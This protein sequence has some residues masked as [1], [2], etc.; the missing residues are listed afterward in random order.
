VLSIATR[1][2]ELDRRLIQALQRDGRTSYAA[3]AGELGTTEKVVRTRVRSLLSSGVIDITTVSNPLALGYRYVAMVGVKTSGAA[4][5]AVAQ[6]LTEIEG[7]DYVVT[8]MGRYDIFVEVF[9]R[10]LDHLQDLIENKIKSIA[11]VVDVEASLY[12]SLV[13]QEGAFELARAKEVTNPIVGGPSI[14]LDDVDI[15]IV[16]ILNQ[17]GRTPYR[18]IAERLSI[19]ESQVRRRVA[20]MQD[21]NVMKIMAITNPMSLGFETVALVGAIVVPPVGVQEAARTIAKIRSVTYV[22][23]AAGRFDLWLELVCSDPGDLLRLIDEELR[24]IPGITRLE[25]FVYLDLRYRHVRTA[26]ADS[27]PA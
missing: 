22:A 15:S 9:C 11:G 1:L 24:Q 2:S 26:G 13:Y 6:Q 10:T 23:I 21:A 14:D 12:L 5:S 19:S 8:T 3:L 27:L 17:D 25:P 16:D 20:R 7:V 4:L 18:I